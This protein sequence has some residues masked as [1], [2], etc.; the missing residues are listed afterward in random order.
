MTLSELKAVNW[1]NGN[2]RLIDQTLLPGKLDHIITS[3]FRVLIEAIKRLQVRGAPAIGITAAYAVVL[4]AKEGVDN[5]KKNMGNWLKDS[6]VMIGASRPT[7]RNLFFALERMKKVISDSNNNSGVEIYNSL[8]KEANVIFSEDEEMCRKIG[9]NGAELIQ[10][11]DGIITHCNTGM[12][13]TAGQGTALGVV[14]TAHK[15]GKNVHVYADET[16][17]LLQGARLTTWECINYDIPVTLLCDNA[18]A[19]L[20][21]S[22]KVNCAIVGADRIAANG[23]TANKIGTYGLAL[24]CKAHDIPFYVAAP[25]S[26]FDFGITSGKEIPIEERKPLEIVKVLGTPIAP[27]EV[28][29]YNPAFD[30]T[31]AELITAIITEEGVYRFP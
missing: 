20:V 4:A 22:G 30:V 21:I 24:I 10:D 2:V 7:A 3:D 19:S 18:A 6:M 31:P 13:V 17:P 12:L 1:D 25:Y 9:A 8:L 28:N 27:Q 23:D 16:R 5:Q 26:T 15:Q 11:G 29:A 14:Y